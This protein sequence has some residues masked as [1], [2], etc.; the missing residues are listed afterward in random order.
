MSIQPPQGAG[1]WLPDPTG[2][3]EY[4][5][6]DGASWTAAVMRAGQ[7]DSDPDFVATLAAVTAA[8]PVAP[9]TPPSAP[10]AAQAP[11][12]SPNDRLT[13]LPPEVAQER[14]SIQLSMLGFQPLQVGPGRIDAVAATKGQANGLLVVLLLLVWIVPGIV[15][16]V[17]AS[18]TTT[19]RV[20]LTFVPN[21]TGTRV[22]VQS[23]TPRGYQ[24]IGPALTQLPW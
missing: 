24:L 8:T 9:P 14:V 16:W 18:R 19:H 11:V 10:A 1:G 17:V 6:W 22:G 13:S 3:Y 5:Y 23:S 12:P 21:G 20:Y 15:Y 7:V 4:R 2:R